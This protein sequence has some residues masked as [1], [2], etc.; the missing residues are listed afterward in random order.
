M[1]RKKE[2]LELLGFL[3]ILCSF[4]LVLFV[5]LV[6][7]GVLSIS[8]SY[9]RFS[10][11]RWRGGVLVDLYTIVAKQSTKNYFKDSV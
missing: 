5:F 9:H 11:Y 7:L 3:K 8:I 6:F 1:I 4:L 2:G 10:Y